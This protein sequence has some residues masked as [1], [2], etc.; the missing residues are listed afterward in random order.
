MSTKHRN[1]RKQVKVALQ[2]KSG[3]VSILSKPEY[4]LAPE[5]RYCPYVYLKPDKHVFVAY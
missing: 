5:F 4:D 1:N 2:G 3:I